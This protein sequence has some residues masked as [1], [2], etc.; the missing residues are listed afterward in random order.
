[1]RRCWWLVLASE[2]YRSL[3]CSG[4]RPQPLVCPRAAAAG[5][6]LLGGCRST[7]LGAGGRGGS[8]GRGD[9]K[10]SW[11][12]GGR[13]GMRHP[14]DL[15]PPFGEAWTGTVA[16]NMTQ[17]GFDMGPVIVKFRGQCP[18]PQGAECE[19]C[20]WRLLHASAALRTGHRV[21]DRAS[22]PRRRVRQTRDRH[23]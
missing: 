6:A 23:Q 1:M 9:D 22:K 10:D 20:V 21:R 8:V 19:D 5:L 11:F 7:P 12:A 15:G 3:R 16:S 18:S 2:S 17:I 13:G 14:M 4:G